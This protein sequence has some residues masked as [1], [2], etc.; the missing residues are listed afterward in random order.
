MTAPAPLL[1]QPDNFTPT[2]RTP[3][4][5]TRL[6][7]RYKPGLGLPAQTRVGEAWEVS[8][9]PSFPSRVLGSDDTLAARIAQEPGAWLGSPEA[10]LGLLVKL[11]DADEPLSLQV[12]P[13]IGDPALL[14]DESGKP[15]GW[16][17]LE[18]TPGAGLYLGFTEGT[19]R[20]QVA[21]C[22][23]EGGDL[24]ALMNFV[25]VRAG[26]AFLIEAGVPHA[27]GAGVTL[28]EPQYVEPGKKGL[29]YR[30]WDWNRRYDPQGLPDAVRGKAR[31]LHV[32]R[33]LAVTDWSCVGAGGVERCRA[34][35]RVLGA[36]GL[37]HTRVLDG[38]WFGAERLEGEGA[39]EVETLGGF[40]ALT[41]TQGEATVSSEAGELRL[42]RGYS[43]VVP[44][45]AGV[46]RVEGRG[47]E[48]W[49]CRA[50]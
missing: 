18:A 28:L 48:L 26:D 38:P 49:V 8:V 6:A 47:L 45:S 44:A 11:L 35:S 23:E 25:P 24:S 42:A 3:W 50:R 2:V 19:S 21:E 30:F 13:A 9:E 4:G 12:H 17:I 22:L 20:A 39:R 40:V 1:L 29:T 7:A 10:R 34:A 5:G 46:F 27:I 37:R 33:S 31:E 16:I 36:E 43:A 15:E 41:C 32:A 14:A